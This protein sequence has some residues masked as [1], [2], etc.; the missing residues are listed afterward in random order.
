MN[1]HSTWRAGDGW[2]DQTAAAWCQG[3][4]ATGAGSHDGCSASGGGYHG[5]S[6]GRGSPGGP[7]E[8]GAPSGRTAGCPLPDVLLEK[9]LSS[10]KDLYIGIPFSARL[11]DDT[12]HHR[13]MDQDL[14]PINPS[15]RAPNLVPCPNFVLWCSSNSSLISVAFLVGEFPWNFSKLKQWVA[16]L[17]MVPSFSYLF[18][19][20]S[21]I[22]PSFC[23]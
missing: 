15:V 22:S 10:D 9:P 8:G 4:G 13:C 12:S 6:R 11:T 17:R 14:Y 1:S 2:R 3:T 7:G 16:Q 21:V 23:Y 5:R 19:V 18:T 20:Y